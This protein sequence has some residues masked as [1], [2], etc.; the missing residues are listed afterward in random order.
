MPRQNEAVAE[1]LE[2]IGDLLSLKGESP[3]RIRAYNEAARAIGAMTEDVDDLYQAGHLT[4]IS[5]IGESL[6][7]KIAEYL[8]TGRL[9]YYEEL[10]RQVP[11]AEADLLEVPS[12]GPA[13]AR[14]LFERLGI[15]GAGDLER[16]AQEHRLQE[17]PGFGAKLE[18]RIGREVMRVRQ[19]ARRMLLGMALPA[20]EEVVQLLRACPA[21]R[22][23]EPAGSLRRVRETIGDIDI[24]VS[25]E[26]PAEVA[27]AFTA[28][29]IVKEILSKG[30]SRSS[31]LI[32][33]DV[34]IDLRILAPDEYGSGLQYFTGS[35]DHNIALRS[36]AIRRGWKL[37]EYGLFDQEGR[38]IA[39]RT[40]GEIYQALG[41]QVIPP[42]LRE[43]RGEIEAAQQQH[44]P[45]LVEVGDVKGDLH[46]HTSWSDGHDPAERMVEA[47]IARG[48][49]YIA[50][51]D[52]SRALKV[53]HG[54]SVER[55]HEQR[56]LIDQLNE[57]YAPFRIL[58]GTE[59]DVLPDG[60]LDYPDEVLAEFDIV[61]ASVHR[62]LGQPAE[63]MTARIVR[64]L[65]NPYV[66]V[67]NH[68]TGRLLLRRAAYDVD[69][70]AI[71]QAARENGV[72]LEIDGQPQ[73][74]DLDDIWSRQAQEAGLLLACNS[75]AHAVR[76]LEYMRYAVATARRGWVQPASILNCLPLQA[77]LARLGRRSA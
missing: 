7:A 61:T 66:D 26:R 69:M 22:E 71:M 50:L 32:A 25:S 36:L 5:G 45:T 23:I 10:R 14:L 64:A 75:D 4:E 15:K 46:V 77:L 57:R 1:L 72:A 17:L 73:R 60:E 47:S 9:H 37:S 24:L 62:A 21:V 20:A 31:V 12:V 6:A 49:E 53:A 40:E 35:K 34:Q 2:R 44:L 8:E 13:R 63:R 76:H 30:P 48:Y 19:R 58:H 65:R 39:G 59:V 41:L 33:Q 3:F 55:V 56:R 70:K 29:P 27:D 67:L 51:T 42:E 43:N 74:L 11:Q 54:L 38:L 52:H 28:L 68:P 16:A 18:E